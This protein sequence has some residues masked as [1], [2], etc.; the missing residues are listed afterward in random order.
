[1]WGFYQEYSIS[2]SSFLFGI[3]TQTFI[4]FLSVATSLPRNFHQAFHSELLAITA[5]SLLIA[6]G[7]FLCIISM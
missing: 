6:P 3:L 1:V 7:Q 2:L 5:S 4:L